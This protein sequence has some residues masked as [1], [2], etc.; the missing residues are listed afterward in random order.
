MSASRIASRRLRALVEGSSPGYSLV[1]LLAYTAVV[2]TTAAFVL[3]FT[4]SSLN[5]MNLTS[6]A[7]NV[8]STTQLAKMR[9]AAD[10]TKARIYV[11]LT[12][13]TFR[14]QRWRKAT[15]VGWIDEGE[16]SNLSP[17]VGFGFGG[18]ATPPPNTQAAIGQAPPCLDNADQPIAGTACIVFNSRGIPVD[19][20][21][22]PT[23]NGAFYVSDGAT[24][25]AITT[26]AGGLVRLWR[27][28]TGGGAWV[29]H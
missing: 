4:R 25:F 15:P 27:S 28:N 12:T 22:A 19:S 8:S 1:E 23:A 11:E 2:V 5:A 14:V 17:T 18:L 16:I 21:N 3:P 10:F 7:R 29:A 9:A 6:D 20:L 24:I 13:G 26:S